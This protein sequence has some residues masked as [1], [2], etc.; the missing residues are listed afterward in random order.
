MEESQ[1]IINSNE[2][3]ELD[4]KLILCKIYYNIPGYFSNTK[5]LQ[6]VYQKK[7]Y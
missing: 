1:I 4:Y 5:A 7:G 6:K 3:Q 2:S